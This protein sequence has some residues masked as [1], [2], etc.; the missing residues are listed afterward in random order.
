MEKVLIISASFKKVFFEEMVNYMKKFETRI[1]SSEWWQGRTSISKIMNE[2]QEFRPDIIYTDDTFSAT[3]VSKLS[4][5][6]IPV[7]IHLRG[8]WWIEFWSNLSWSW[9]HRLYAPVNYLMTNLSFKLADGFVPICKWLEKDVNRRLP[10]KKTDVVYQGV[11]PNIFYPE[12]GMEFE[13]PCV[14]IVQS[15]HILPKVEGL[16]NFREVV[17]RLPGVNFKI[18]G[19]GPHLERVK[20]HFRKEK[21]VKVIGRVSYPQELRQFLTEIDVY[22]LPSGLDC[23]PTT[24]LEAGLMKKPVLGSA[25]GG[26]PEIIDQGKTGWSIP[27]G[28]FDSWVEK[29][30]LLLD[31]SRKARKMGSYGRKWVSKNF[32]WKVVSKQV[33]RIF[34]A[35]LER[36]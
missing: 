10:G 27:N 6:K 30:G 8:N 3:I 4:N 11:T 23:C 15:H 31:D 35:Y 22:V 13:H 1:I 5:N 24:I 25:V 21:N 12:K 16:L 20:N 29:I 19:D 17:R 26:I 14:G 32:D 18:A 9:K 33:S 28:D 36:R 34:T 7:L 2:I